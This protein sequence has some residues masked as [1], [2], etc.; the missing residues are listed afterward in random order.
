MLSIPFLWIATLC[1]FLMEGHFRDWLWNMDKD[2]S[3]E[4]QNCLDFTHPSFLAF[5][6]WRFVKN[7]HEPDR[8]FWPAVEFGSRPEVSGSLQ[9]LG[10]TGGNFLRSSWS[11][12]V[13]WRTKSMSA[14]KMLLP[15]Y[16]ISRK[17]HCW[18][19]RVDYAAPSRR[20]EEKYTNRHLIR[21]L[22]CGVPWWD[23]LVHGCIDVNNYAFWYGSMP[24]CSLIQ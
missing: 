23:Q 3:E 17:I 24:W 2:F 7:M 15:L 10:R 16:F 21:P 4:G 9:S 19:L 20:R 5:N 18:F 22:S 1:P 13:R 12:E 11:R 14:M 8:D 6:G